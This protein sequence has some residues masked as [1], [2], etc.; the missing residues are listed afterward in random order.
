MKLKYLIA[1]ELERKGI[2][3][4]HTF[5]GLIELLQLRCSE[6]LEHSAKIKKYLYRGFNINY[7]TDYGF[8]VDPSQRERKS[9]SGY[10]YHT[11]LMDNL[12]EWSRF[13][14]RSKSLI[15]STDQATAAGFAHSNFIVFPY[16]GAKFGICPKRDLQYSFKKFSSLADFEIR[17][18]SAYANFNIETYQELIKVLE[19]SNNLE[20]IR[21]LL[22]PIANDFKIGYY[23]QLPFGRDQEVWAESK[24]VL[25][26]NQW[27]LNNE[28]EIYKKLVTT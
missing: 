4:I 16:D 11:L 13:P 27:W 12:P 7:P 14:K 18:Q 24:C 20:V 26:E 5:D 1:E 25:V 6:A 3:F 10:N 23:H 19:D 2:N 8:K 28:D 21:D 22:K 15:C 17:L 9:R